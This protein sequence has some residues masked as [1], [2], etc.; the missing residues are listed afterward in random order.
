MLPSDLCTHQAL[1]VNFPPPKKKT[2]PIPFLPDRDTLVRRMEKHWGP[3]DS[4][5]GI[6]SSSAGG[7]VITG[8]QIGK[9]WIGI[10]PMLGIEGDPMRLL[11]DRDLTPHPQYAA[12]YLWLQVPG[13]GEGLWTGVAIVLKES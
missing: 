2:G 8:V 4:Y 11:F 3:L 13:M 6:A 9:V 5:R 7:L 1:P 12:F 10:Q